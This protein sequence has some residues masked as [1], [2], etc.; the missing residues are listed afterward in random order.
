MYS[1]TKL[2]RSW[3]SR[4]VEYFGLFVEFNLLLLVYSS[5][6]SGDIKRVNIH[7]T[8]IDDIQTGVERG[9]W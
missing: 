8:K 3:K 5:T 4:N 6:H 1:C 2:T 9:G 7:I